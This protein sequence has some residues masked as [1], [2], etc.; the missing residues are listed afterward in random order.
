[1]VVIDSSFWVSL[2]IKGDSNYIK[3]YEKYQTVD[4]GKIFLTDQ[5][6]GET[7][8]VI[9]RIGKA[10]AVEQFLHLLEESNLSYNTMDLSVFSEAIKIFISSPKLSFVDCH[11]LATAIKTRSE[12]LSF[13]NKQLKAFERLKNRSKLQ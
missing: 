7:L 9:K 3:A 1:M 10:S 2:L 11:V 5:V 4:L 8:T 13:D 6:L 12:I